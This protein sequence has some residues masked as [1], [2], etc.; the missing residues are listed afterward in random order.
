MRHRKAGVHLSRTS[1][2]RK[3]LFSNL[4]AALLTNERIRTTDAKAKETRRLAE[5]T[6]TWARRVGD[7]LTKKPD[8]RTTEE[9][10]RVVHAVRMARRVVRDRGAV[11]KLFDEIAPRFVGRRGG[12]TRIVK[13]G[14]RPG[15]AA[16]MSLLELMPDEGGPSAAP[17]ET[18]AKGEGA[19]AKSGKAAAA[20]AAKG[21][22]S[23]AKAQEGEGD[24][25][26]SKKSTAKTP[27]AKSPKK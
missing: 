9:S 2:H 18:P 4:V 27:A 11:M 5:R 19:K 26:G 6:I 8:R 25:A 15:D 10:A 16:P 22:K 21:S 3:A 14:Q 17:A 7:V 13:L 20:P 24:K 12:Y 1:A 23:A